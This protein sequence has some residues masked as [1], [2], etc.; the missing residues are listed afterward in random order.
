MSTTRTVSSALIDQLIAAGVTKIFGNPGTTEQ[1][2]LDELQDHEGIDL[3]LCLHEGIAI[4][5]AEGWARA[6]GEVAVVQLHAA[7]GLGNGMGMLFN[8]WCGSVPMVVI[9]GQPP[10]AALHQEP[11]LN[12]DFAAM[13]SP[14]AKYVH[15]IRTANEVPQV[16]RRALKAAA[17]TPSGP[18]LVVL[19]MDIA[20]QECT[21]DVTP[22][23]HIPSKV[24][25][26]PVAIELSVRLINQAENPAIIVGDW[27][28]T[29][30][31]AAEVGRLAE[32]IGAP[33]F[34]GFLAESAVEPSQPLKAEILPFDGVAASRRLE[35]HD[36]IVAIGTKLF[37]QLF[38]LDGPP[39]GSR[40][41]VHIGHDVWEIGKNQPCLGVIGDEEVAVRELVDALEA[42]AGGQRREQ[43]SLRREQAVADIKARKAAALDRDRETRFDSLTAERAIS[44]CADALPKDIVVCDQA[45][46]SYGVVERYFST[47][48]GN[49]FRNRGGGIGSA[50]SMTIGVQYA[51]PDSR[52]VCF[53]G[54]GSAM[55]SLTAMWT[56][57]H[58]KLP[59]IWVIL[60][61]KS[62][63]MVILNTSQ[64]AVNDRGDRGVVGADLSEP[65]I[66]FVKIASGMGVAAE[67]IVSA[68][69]IG[70]AVE[71]AI[72]RTDQPS[73]LHIV[74]DTAS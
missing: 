40:E 30:G 24:R 6:S 32:L 17:T 49:S 35:A 54:D 22:M 52:V 44:A 20:E 63:R 74:L 12:L 8:A 33:I 3:V 31:C 23:S 28:A 51:R 58:H 41:V 48:P 64:F 26:D 73:L 25:P 21:T 13:V 46:T 9:I 56:A 39:L 71:R 37:M 72:A 69:E 34:G 61:N 15:E 5:A 60:D 65:P 55:Y 53:S 66:E 10:L 1:A 68:A 2:W 70:P 59:I 18:V 16:I 29:P 42:Q 47:A 14:L 50:M 38:T 36:T 43:W 4:S 7:P 11:N 45:I 62:Y 67:Q 27:A 57:A 19:P